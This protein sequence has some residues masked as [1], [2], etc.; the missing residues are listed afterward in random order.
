MSTKTKKTGKEKQTFT[1]KEMLAKALGTP[2]A[3]IKTS[4]EMLG[5]AD[6]NFKKSMELAKGKDEPIVPYKAPIKKNGKTSQ[7]VMKEVEE[8]ILEQESLEEEKNDAEEIEIV[9]VVPPKDKKLIAQNSAQAQKILA[10][11]PKAKPETKMTEE[12]KKTARRKEISRIALEA[13]R[14][15][16]EAAAAKE[17]GIKSK[18]APSTLPE[19]KVEA[20]PTRTKGNNGSTPLSKMTVA[21]LQSVKGTISDVQWN[22]YLKM[23]NNREG[24]VVIKSNPKAE[25]MA[26]KALAEHKEK[27]QH[28]RTRTNAPQAEVPSLSYDE[29]IK[30]MIDLYV[31]LGKFLN[32][33]NG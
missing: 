26:E 27:V 32:S 21:E 17:L 23:A 24:V 13:K 29:T 15:K 25:A 4:D 7:Q 22:K 33:L 18:P 9:E 12:E 5:D 6:E 20:K 31:K 14:A 8:E 2:T 30:G 11:A 3:K 28:T 1:Y 19:K 16:K 10:K